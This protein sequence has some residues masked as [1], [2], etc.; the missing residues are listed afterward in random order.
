MALKTDKQR[1][2][3]MMVKRERDAERKWARKQIITSENLVEKLKKEFKKVDEA[4]TNLRKLVASQD[5]IIVTAKSRLWLLAT[6]K[7][8]GEIV[9]T[10]IPQYVLDEFVEVYSGVTAKLL[11]WAS[12]DFSMK[13]VFVIVVAMTF[14]M[15]ATY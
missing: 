7:F 10:G 3:E 12:I 6:A 13:L 2:A 11:V 4:L 8:K 1:E 15:G 14:S 9:A 5:S